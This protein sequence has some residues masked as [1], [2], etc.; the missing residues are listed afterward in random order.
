MNARDEPTYLAAARIG[1][2]SGE[3]LSPTIGRAL[4]ERIERDAAAL[5]AAQ[6]SGLKPGLYRNALGAE[7]RVT[8]LRTDRN[9]IGAMWDAEQRD[10]L[11]GTRYLLVTPQGMHECGY[12]FIEA[13]R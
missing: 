1:V 6:P 2:N 13:T 4:L 8:A 5:K 3:R 7:V 12:T 11:F 9:F 10:E